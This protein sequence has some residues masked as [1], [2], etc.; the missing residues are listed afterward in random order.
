MP[1]AFSLCEILQDKYAVRNVQNPSYGYRKDRPTD[2]AIV[3]EVKKGSGRKIAQTQ[4]DCKTDFEKID[5]SWVFWWPTIVEY[6]F[7]RAFEKLLGCWQD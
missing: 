7:D 2:L 1:M 5:P 6:K 3:R 4:I